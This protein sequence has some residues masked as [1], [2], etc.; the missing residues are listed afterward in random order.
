VQERLGEAGFDPGSADGVAGRRT[1][2]ALRA[3][4][5]ARGLSAS[6]ELDGPTLMALGIE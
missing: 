3:F 5:V 6:G 1:Q 2:S 4:Q